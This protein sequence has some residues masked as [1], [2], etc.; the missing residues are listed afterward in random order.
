MYH[1]TF[2]SCKTEKLNYIPTLLLDKCNI[3][4]GRV[5]SAS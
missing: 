2:C 4:G 5:E 3:V 1:E